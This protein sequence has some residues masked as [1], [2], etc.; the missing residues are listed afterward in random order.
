M[1]APYCCRFVDRRVCVGGPF[2]R[3]NVP[4][5]R[6]LS[7]RDFNRV[8]LDERRPLEQAEQ[9]SAKPVLMFVIPVAPMTE[10]E[11]ANYLWVQRT[12]PYRAT[13]YWSLSVLIGVACT[14]GPRSML[15]GMTPFQSESLYRTWV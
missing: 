7:M 13:R 5:G 6:Q 10:C 1:G 11:P 9:V 3:T 2:Q 4:N 14:N 8:Q 12:P 15:V